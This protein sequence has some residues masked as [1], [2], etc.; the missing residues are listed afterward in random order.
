MARYA[1]RPMS[2]GAEDAEDAQ[3]AQPERGVPRRVWS[4]TA[5]QVLGRVWGSICTLLTL[6]LL[7]RHLAGDSFGRFT[8]YLTVFALLDS[9]T[10]FGTGT[11]AV[12]RTAAN[13]WAVPGVL[14]STRRV[15]LALA[16][17][18]ALGVTA[19]AFLL[20]EPGAPWILLATLYQLTHAFELSAVVFKNRV[21]WGIPVAVRALAATFR[22]ALVL[23]LWR[24]GVQ[25]PA[26]YLL[27][28]A[29]GSSLANVLLHRAARPHIPRPTIPVARAR[30]ILREAWPLGVAFL[31]QQLYFYVDNLFVL[32]IEGDTELGRYNGGVRIMSFLIMTATYASGSALPW[33]VRRGG[34]GSAGSAAA[35]LGQ[36]LFAA[37]CLGCGA[38]WPWS[39]ELLAFVLGDDFAS[40]GP[41]LAWLLM[42]CAAVAAGAPLLTTVVAAGRPMHVLAV[43]GGALLLNTVGNA[44]LVPRYG[45]TGAALA[46]F[47]T[48]VAVALGA[49]VALSRLGSSAFR[50]R[51]WRWLVGPVAFAVAA[52]LSSLLPLA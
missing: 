13:P 37:A 21:A 12:R 5:L 11:V 46:T 24:L 34:E 9:L 42:A 19:T 17:L 30:G 28:T 31:C 49:A 36:P 20:G 26:L 44:L 32:L 6:A 50:W 33:L 47:V 40:A 43:A 1:A 52:W 14:A 7:A 8:F 3:D 35:Q 51:P 2:P 29:A 10:D 4:A 45:I 25:S 27:G 16:S 23:G 41:S 38:L 48:E 15:R 18:G 39:S 22:L